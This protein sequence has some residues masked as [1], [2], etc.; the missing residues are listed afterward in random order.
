MDLI[1]HESNG[2]KALRTAA[3]VCVWL[4]W[5]SVLVGFFGGLAAKDVIFIAPFG[6]GILGL[7]VLYLA[8]C[9]IRGFETVVEAA[10]LYR[11]LNDQ[12]EYS[13]EYAE[14]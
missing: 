12:K 9:V 5:L 11:D 8:A 10:Q 4:G 1:N 13:A 7:G 6:L 3:T 2:A 14:E